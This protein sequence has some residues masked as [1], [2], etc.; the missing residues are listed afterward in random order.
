M[1]HFRSG[2][3]ILVANSSISENVGIGLTNFGGGGSVFFESLGNNF[4]RGNVGGDT[5]GTITVVPAH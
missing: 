3:T 2:G 5:S 4:V 1:N